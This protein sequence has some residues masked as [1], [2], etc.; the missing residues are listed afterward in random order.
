MMGGNPGAVALGGPAVPNGLALKLFPCCYALQR[1]IAAAQRL[2]AIGIPSG[3]VAAIK[4]RTPA[5][6]V[7]PLIHQR[8][9]TGLQAKFSLEYGI[10]TGLFDEHPGFA[11]FSDHSVA[12]EQAQ[13]LVRL[14]EVT[15]ASSGDGLLAEDLEIDLTMRD[16]KTH[17]EAIDFPPGSPQ[18]PASKEQIDAKLVQCGPEVPDLLRDLSWGRAAEIML[19]Q[20]CPN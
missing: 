11:S 8:P 5:S 3:Q 13:R 17:R 2:R 10:A 1:P 6:S 15:Q 18:R 19:E 16:G 9:V 12:R 4:L 14:V 7:Q 20:S